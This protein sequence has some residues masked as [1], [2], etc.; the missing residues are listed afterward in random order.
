MAGESNADVYASL[1]VNSA[2]L[3]SSNRE[4]HEQNMLALDVAARDGDDAIVLA[5]EDAGEQDI[6]GSGKDKFADPSDGDNGF[7]QVRI[8]TEGPTETEEFSKGEEVVENTEEAIEFE[9][10]GETPADLTASSEQL[11]QHETG[12]Q[13]M[14]NQAAERGLPEDAIMRI[15]SE[16]EGDGIS[17]ESYEQLAA[18]GYSRAFVDAYISGQE[19]LVDSYVNQ[20]VAFAGG[21]ERFSALHAHLEANNPEAAQTLETALQSRDIGTLKAIINLAG[22]S[23]NAKFGRKAARSVTQRAVPAQR[24]VQ[25]TEGFA[26]RDEMVKAM[27][28]SR[29]RHD[30]AFR[31]EVERK[32]L[33]S[34]F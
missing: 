9:P 2:V 30:N 24:Q 10:L 28:D 13:E 1:G 14:V 32:L 12:F 16:Y 19:A 34:N 11:G 3:T 18:A 22:Q 8:G 27:S 31:M 21:Q 25:K 20:V 4:E 26:T 23:Y 29:Y 15:H 33:A 17:D 7:V 6:Y 5:D